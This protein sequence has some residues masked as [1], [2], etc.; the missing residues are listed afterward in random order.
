[1]L[2]PIALKFANVLLLLLKQFVHL[3][4][5]LGQDGASTLV[6]LLVAQLLDL[7][8]GLLSVY[9]RDNTNL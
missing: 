2:V 3:D 4:V 8:L 9:K 5:V 7:G 1:M 6:V